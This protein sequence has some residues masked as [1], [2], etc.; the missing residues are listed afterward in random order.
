MI[1]PPNSIRSLMISETPESRL[2]NHF[3]G[4]SWSP[5]KVKSIDKK[6][7][8]KSIYPAAVI[9]PLFI[10]KDLESLRIKCTKMFYFKIN[11]LQ[12]RVISISF[13]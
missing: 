12:L 1:N 4:V 8:A 3:N 2:D 7:N 6:P 13:L 11:L 10:M 9:I 5:T